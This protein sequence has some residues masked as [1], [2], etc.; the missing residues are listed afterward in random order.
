MIVITIFF[1]IDG[2]VQAPPEVGSRKKYSLL[3]WLNFKWVQNFTV[4]G[5]GTV[6]GQ[7]SEWWSL[8]QMLH[9]NVQVN[10]INKTSL[11]LFNDYT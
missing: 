5:T 9:Y 2:T 4:Q 1:Q 8:S 3:Q 6:D 11:L 7:G 10:R